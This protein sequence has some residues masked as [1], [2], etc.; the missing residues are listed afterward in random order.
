MA[1][2]IST[3][4]R[5]IYWLSITLHFT[6]PTTDTICSAKH[7]TNRLGLKIASFLNWRLPKLPKEHRSD[8]YLGFRIGGHIV[9]EMKNQQMSLFQFYSY[10]DESLHVSDP[11]AHLQESSH[12]CSHNHWFSVC[13]VQVACSVYGALD[14]NGTDTEP[15]VV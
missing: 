6:R 2:C 11:Q 5:H 9:Y 4:P 1:V 8:H 14:V 3:L 13:T 10:I 15:M 12:S 7:M